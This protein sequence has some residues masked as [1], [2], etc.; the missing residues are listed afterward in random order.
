MDDA[1]KQQV[2]EEAGNRCE[3]CHLGQDELP[4]ATFHID[5]II[6][7]KHGGGDDR[8]NLALAC[9]QCNLHKGSNLA[10]IDPESGET[11]KL[12]NPQTQEWEEH[13]N[14]VDGGIVGLSPTG[15]ATVVVCNMNTSDRVQLRKELPGG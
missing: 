4:Y 1:T 15:R 12:F 7:K 9:Q 11:V 6:P 14:V 8:S 10:G 2:R 3:Y 13:F 5:H